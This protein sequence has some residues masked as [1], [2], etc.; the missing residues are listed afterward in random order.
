MTVRPWIPA[1]ALLALGS[2]TTALG[3][4][5]EGADLVLCTTVS[6]TECFADGSCIADEPEAW[7]IP[8]FVSVDLVQKTLSTTRASGVERTT[9]IATLERHDDRIFIQ[10]TERGRAFSIV[11]NP[12][13][14]LAS[15]GIALDG[16]VLSVFAYCTPLDSTD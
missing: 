15:T 1:L 3:D 10:G 6:A 11:L 13:T 2:V 12:A 14:G 4:S 5:L 16:N 8:R 9:S 7:N